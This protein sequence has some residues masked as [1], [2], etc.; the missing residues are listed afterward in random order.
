VPEREDT[1]FPSPPPAVQIGL[2]EPVGDYWAK[3]ADQVM[4]DSYAGVQMFKF[5]EDLRVYEHLMW[6]S[7]PDV[8]IEIGA[9]FGGSALWFRDRLRVLAGYGRSRNPRVVSLELDAAPALSALAKADPDFAASIT[10]VEGDVCDP[11]TANAVERLVPRGARCMVV[12]DSAHT[13]ETTSAALSHYAGFVDLGGFF[14]VEDGC[15][16]IEAMRVSDD[17]PRGVL[18]ALH[19]WLETPEGA[20]FRVRRDLEVYGISC[21]PEGFLQRVA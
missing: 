18:P 19:E 6:L 17:W 20:D 1:A 4:R 15:V 21:H 12:E 7:R 8:V 11:S 9:Y 5:P 3:R 16:D 13:F 2:D 14:V 10:I